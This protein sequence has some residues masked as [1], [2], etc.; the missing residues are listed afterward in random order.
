MLK[1]LRKREPRRAWRSVLDRSAGVLL[2][3]DRLHFFLERARF[4]ADRR[5]GQFCLLAITLDEKVPL[6]NGPDVLASLLHERLR[7][8]DDMG[9]LGDGRIGVILPDTDVLGVQRVAE[10]TLEIFLAAGGTF[11][12][13]VYVYPSSEDLPGMPEDDAATGATTTARP[14]RLESLFTSPLPVWKRCLD[15]VGSLVLMVVFAPFMFLAML[16]V[17][18]TSPGPVLFVQSRHGLGGEPF[19]MFKFR[20]MRVGA[21]AEKAQLRQL[22]EQDG[23]AFKMKEDP[24][25]TPVGKWLRATSID[26]L[27]QLLNVLQGTMS[28]VGPR[29]LPVEESQGCECWQRRRLDVTPGLTCI[30]QVHG[31][32]RVS[33]AEWIR[34]DLQYIESMSLLKDLKLLMLT[35]A[36]V[37]SRKGSH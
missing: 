17:R 32:S 34:M 2:P 28:L 3:A 29:P 24:R 15:V 16:A 36:S 14:L 25:I 19:W 13:E 1:L 20:T 8:T 5:G 27:P 4:Q 23:P 6:E 21:D 37:L 33:F 18:F 26:E 30:W 9:L 22:S 31:R 35:V 7:I 12:Y 10:D 11:R